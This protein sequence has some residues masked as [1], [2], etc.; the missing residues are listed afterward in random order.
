MRQHG[1]MCLIV[2][3]WRC[4]PAFPLLLAANR[5]EEHARPTEAAH[6]WSS[7]AGLFGGRDARAGGTWCGADR[8]GRFATVTNVR[9]PGAAAGERSRGALVRDYFAGR[10]SAHAWARRVWAG[11]GAYSPFNLLVGDE[12][13]LWFVSNHGD[14]APRAIEPGVWAV[15]NGHWGDAWPKTTR[16]KR[17]LRAR[18]NSDHVTAGDLLQL[19]TDTYQPADDALPATGVSLTT[20]R[21]LAPIFIVGER[22]GTRASTVLRR[23]RH[24]GVDFYERG[25]D[26]A[27]RARH[28]IEQHWTVDRCS[29]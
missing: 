23:D 6:W 1:S 18:L 8:H 16:A 20:E 14:D 21:V 13:Q 25:F 2:L 26:R 11:G 5:D 10:A 3:A 9:D 24:G 27:G 4:Y 28:F 29:T 12:E 17:A 22:Y 7:P 15:S 19:L